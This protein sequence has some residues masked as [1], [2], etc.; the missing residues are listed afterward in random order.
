MKFN[1]NRV[2]INRAQVP[3]VSISEC[4]GEEWVYS[5]FHSESHQSW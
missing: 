5:Q 2:V 1:Q 4:V 3:E